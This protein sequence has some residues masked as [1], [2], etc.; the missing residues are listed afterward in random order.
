MKKRY[1]YGHLKV[2]QMAPFNSYRSS[3]KEKRTFKESKRLRWN[4]MESY[5]ILQNPWNHIESYRIIQNHMESLEFER[6]IENPWNPEE[7]TIPGFRAFPLG[8]ITQNGND[9]KYIMINTITID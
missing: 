2:I 5:G 6:I 7:L 8:N 3:L 4:P 9:E 1:R